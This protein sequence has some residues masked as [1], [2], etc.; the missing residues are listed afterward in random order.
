MYYH[1][2]LFIFSTTT[3]FFLGI[4]SPW[5]SMLL[6]SWVLSS[7]KTALPRLGLL[8]EWDSVGLWGHFAAYFSDKTLS[9]LHYF[10]ECSGTYNKHVY[11]DLVGASL[12]WP[13]FFVLRLPAQTF[14]GLVGEEASPIFRFLTWPSRL[15]SDLADILEGVPPSYT[16]SETSMRSNISQ[17]YL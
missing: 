5:F 4:V 13:A 17:V 10:E 11:F 3:F 2:S 12:G 6:T 9:N 14:S 15:T 7:N 16:F 8:P 1:L